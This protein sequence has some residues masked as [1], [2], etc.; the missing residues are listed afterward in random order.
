METVKYNTVHALTGL[1]AVSMSCSLFDYFQRNLTIIY[2]YKLLRLKNSFISNF[3]S[4]PPL[5]KINKENKSPFKINLHTSLVKGI[6][7]SLYSSMINSIINTEI[8]RN[9]PWVET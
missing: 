3:M 5:I 2:V 4:I 6:D 9:H 8:Y 1:Y 7:I